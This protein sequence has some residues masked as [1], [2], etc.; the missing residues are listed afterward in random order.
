MADPQGLSKLGAV[1]QLTLI[2]CNL[3]ATI[4]ICNVDAERSSL[5]L[6]DEIGVG[7]SYVIVIALETLK[8][9]PFFP[10]KTLILVSKWRV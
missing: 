1:Q 3:E 2:I 10:L 6:T 5:R 4:P 9:R 8:K 7:P